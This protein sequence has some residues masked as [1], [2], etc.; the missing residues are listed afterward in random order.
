TLLKLTAPGVPDIYQ[1]NEIWEFTLVDPDNRRPV[2][3]GRRRAL[4]AEVRSGGVAPR[5]AAEHLEDGRGKLLLTWKCLELRRAH[6][7]LFRD[8]SYRRLRQQS[9]IVIAPRLYRRLLGEGAGLPLGEA[10]WGDTLIELP[11]EDRSR[12]S[13]R[14][15]L[16]RAQLAPVRQGESVGVRAAEALAAFPVA[17]LAAGCDEGAGSTRQPAGG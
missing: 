5:T 3:Y 10:V 17:L 15:V 6:P 12:A 11:R 8:G 16:D 13:F 9:L 7:E 4:L 2:D 14:N 1:G